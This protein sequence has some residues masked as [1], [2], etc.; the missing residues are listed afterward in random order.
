MHFACGTVGITCMAIGVQ[1]A[2]RVAT[3]AR[4]V[5]ISWE[6]D[7]S[8]QRHT[9]QQRWRYTLKYVLGYKRLGCHQPSLKWN[10]FETS[11]HCREVVAISEV[12]LS[13]VQLQ[14]IAFDVVIRRWLIA[15][16]ELEALRLARSHQEQRLSSRPGPSWGLERQEME[17]GEHTLEPVRLGSILFSLVFLSHKLFWSLVFI[18]RDSNLSLNK[19]RCM[20]KAPCHDIIQ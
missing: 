5:Q 20:H 13:E 6:S 12:P 18:F 11:V 15:D 1:A 3:A 2:E 4:V 19:D 17:T 9:H 16:R 8:S 10:W 14:R 7:H